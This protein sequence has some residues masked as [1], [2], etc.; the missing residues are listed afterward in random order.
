M[1]IKNLK[2]RECGR[3][4]PPKAIYVC[5][6]C[7]G[8]LEV[9]YDYDE[10]SKEFTRKSITEKPYSLWRYKG[11]LPVETDTPVSLFEGMTPL[12][13]AKNL[14]KELGLK[15]LYV[16]NDSVNPTFSFKDRVVTVAV[17]R[18]KELGFDTVA[19]AS[20]GNL[21]CSVAAYGK[22]A[23]LKTTVFIPA[24]LEKGKIIGAGI[25]HPNLVG[26]KGD[27]DDV[28]KLCG[29]IAGNYG[30]GFV[31]INLRPYYA[32]G[33]KTL[34]FE[35]A[36]QLNWEAPE[37]VVV[38]MASGSLLTKIHKGLNEFEKLG[39]IEDASTKMYGAQARGADPIARAVKN[40]ADIIK[41]QKTK[42]V[43]KSL[44]IGNPA[45]GYYAKEVIEKSGGTAES[46]TDSEVVEGIKLLAAKEGIFTET[47]GGVTVGVLKKLI[48]KGKID[49]DKRTVIYITGNGLKTQEA[50]E[51][52]VAKVEKIKPTINSFEKKCKWVKGGK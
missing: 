23:N 31:N 8:P 43:A 41:P 22:R 15:E 7:F 16:K 25:Y 9:E 3:R 1:K 6:Y 19:C 32:E 4:Y 29:E 5:E 50:V 42:T 24:N 47:A 10:I 14:E 51:N 36:E 38:P 27:Y 39:I 2:C 45:D 34:G 30:W 33:S 21:A 52:A 20:T 28:N 46:V 49:P 12:V 37:Q 18:A 11:L 17:S 44:A 35:V 48:R 13:R 40:K 26:V